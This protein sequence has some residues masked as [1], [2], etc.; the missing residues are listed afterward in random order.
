[1]IGILNYLEEWL[2][3]IVKFVKINNGYVVKE[4]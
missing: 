1:M 4:N 3:G 2:E